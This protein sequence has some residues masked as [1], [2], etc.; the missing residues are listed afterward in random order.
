MSIFHIQLD[1]STY[2]PGAKQT[3]MDGRVSHRESG[4]CPTETACTGSSQDTCGINV[5]TYEKG[6]SF[7][8][9]CQSPSLD[10][11]SGSCRM[12]CAGEHQQPHSRYINQRQPRSENQMSIYELQN[13]KITLVIENYKTWT[14]ELRD[15]LASGVLIT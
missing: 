5:N 2:Y 15:M 8:N 7:C 14:L 6:V 9:C 13:M 3:D 12:T 4:F 11:H 10:F 1:H